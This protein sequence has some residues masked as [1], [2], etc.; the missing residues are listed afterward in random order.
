MIILAL[1]A[2][3]AS[4]I[5]EILVFFVLGLVRQPMYRFLA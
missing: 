5:K 1:Y 2:L 3:V 4:I